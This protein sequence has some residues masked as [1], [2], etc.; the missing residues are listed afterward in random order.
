MENN[1]NLN[2]HLNLQRL[3][4]QKQN[5]NQEQQVQNEANETNKPASQEEFTERGNELFDSMEYIAMRGRGSVTR[6]GSGKSGAR[7]I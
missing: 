2:R 6:S 4:N 7:N 1:V 3:N 5:E